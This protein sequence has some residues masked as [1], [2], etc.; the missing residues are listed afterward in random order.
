MKDIGY[1]L[2]N[3][4]NAILNLDPQKELLL[5]KLNDAVLAIKITDLNATFYLYPK[6]NR[7]TVS[8]KHPQREK[9]TKLTGNIGSL[10]A[11]GISPDPQSY[12]HNKSIHFEGDMHTLQAY[13][14]LFGAIRPDLLFHLNQ[15]CK[16]PLADLLQKPHDIA[17]E[18]LK[19]NHTNTLSD[20]SEYLQEEKRLFPPQEEMEDF[21][22]DVQLLKEDL[23]R[24]QAKF[25]KLS[26][27]K[28]SN[29]QGKKDA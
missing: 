1:I 19:L 21:F 3:S 7:L 28:H 15:T 22:D 29:P 4:I 14:Q 11:M 12:L 24:V 5:Q 25:A 6:A 18:W 2:D 27:I 13:Y 23:D 20:L 26:Q 8:K 16:L 10:F 17:K 9:F